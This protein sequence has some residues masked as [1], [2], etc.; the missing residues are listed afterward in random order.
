MP[1]VIIL[2]VVATI[3]GLAAWRVIADNP[4]FS[5]PQNLPINSFEKCVKAGG[6]VY[7]DNRVFEYTKNAYPRTG[8]YIAAGSSFYAQPDRCELTSKLCTDIHVGFNNFCQEEY[9]VK[10][11][12]SVIEA[13]SKVG[14]ITEMLPIMTDGYA[15][16]AGRCTQAIEV[17][18]E[19]PQ[20]TA[21][22]KQQQNGTWRVFKS[23]KAD[24]PCEELDGIGIPAAIAQLCY[25]PQVGWRSPS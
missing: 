21:F 20:V 15:R 17:K 24:F 1:I 22:L 6:K 18:P 23:V 12:I 16:T 13:K 4:P 14:A 19:A 2:L 25:D 9:A 5:L 11:D 8:C 10:Y 3:I 7:L